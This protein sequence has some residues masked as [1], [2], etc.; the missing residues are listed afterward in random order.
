MARA[1]DA[2][3]AAGVIH[4]D[5]KPSNVMLTGDRA[6]VTDFGLARSK[7]AET[8]STASLSGR[9][10]GTVDYM[11]PELLAGKPAT[12]ASDIY[13]LGMV[14]YK[15]VTGALPFASDTPL[16]A[17]ILR[18]K[19]PIPSPKA[20]VS[21]LDPRW[22]RAILRALDADQSRRFAT[23]AD[24][25]RALR[26]ESTAI[27]LALPVMSRR[28]WIA[29]AAAVL[30]VAGGAVGWRAWMKARRRP[31]P[32]AEMLYRKGVED[33]A[34]GAY[35]A[36]TKALQEA[37]KVAPHF[38]LARA[39]LAEAWVELEMPEK[40]QEQM[41]YAEREDAGWLSEKERLQIEAIYLTVTRDYTGAAA[42]YEQLAKESDT[43]EMDVDLG[44]AY[45]K[46]GKPEKA[47]ESYLRAAESPEHNPA[48]WLRLGVLYARQSNA[49]K[50]TNA[51]E[52]AERRY[53]LTSNL[54]GLTELAIQRGV[55]LAARGMLPQ[56]RDALKDAVED[57]R[58]AGNIQQTIN[59]KL[60]LSTVAYLSGDAA[61]TERLAGEAVETARANGMD[62]L[63]TRGLIRLGDAHGRR[64]EFEAAER[65]YNDA[66]ALA[67]H[68]RSAHLEALSHLSLSSFYGQRDRLDESVREAEEALKYYQ[69]NR[70]AKESIQCLLLL[71]R[72]KRDRSDTT[73]AL[74]LFRQALRIAE[75]SQDHL[76][77]ALAHEGIGSILFDEEL[78]PQALP[79]YQESLRFAPDAEHLG[80]AALQCANTLWRLG[81]YDE[82]RSMFE[83]A[84]GLGNSFP[85]LSMRV[86]QGQADMLL[87]QNRLSEA[88]RTIRRGLAME[89]GVSAQ[90]GASMRQT[91]GLVLLGMGDKS[92]LLDCKQALDTGK[93]LGLPSVVTYATVTVMQ[94]ESQAGNKMAALQTFR[95]VEP[96]LNSFPELRWRALA[97]ASRSDPR[98]GP[99]ARHA[100]DSLAKAWGASAIATYRNRPD[101][102]S[103]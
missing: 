86:L 30:L 61:L 100:F 73:S 98:L 29:V 76:Q 9:V 1:L 37:V 95:Q 60:R 75:S 13:A 80:Y 3:H 7:I 15:M 5:F 23:A 22:E 45:E 64:R 81:R 19:E 88:L 25:V 69:P 77:M 89:A 55:A 47:I 16:A 27:T 62:A 96:A 10:M 18:S 52:Q 93:R 43:P 12:F 65:Y 87:S 32:E 103:V 31:S 2:A 6:V 99:E 44:R 63:A 35:F 83:K 78:F 102:V 97:W 92:G 54:E 39:R 58:R 40:A 101:I 41:L 51:F 53:Q 57:A 49:E 85:A 17:A 50:A 26:G 94:A 91:L 4:R 56:A 72:A 11:A 33:I 21:G 68:E 84:E 79:E 46:P 14:A 74:D 8:E 42:K 70:F 24:F 20:F 36:A 34:A 38:A 82:A 28:K 67:Q 71:A 66:L 48:A 90:T 59:A